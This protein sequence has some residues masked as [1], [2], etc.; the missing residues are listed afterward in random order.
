MKPEDLELRKLA[1]AAGP[2]YGWYGPDVF[3]DLE[4]QESGAYIAAA[5]PEAI[6]SLLERLEKAEK[7]AERY[8]F[9]R[10]KYPET[11]KPTDIT[12]KDVDRLTDSAMEARK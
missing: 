7:D 9:W 1:E 4:F 10:D 5:S 3:K 6:L 11:F 12:P 8:R 2:E